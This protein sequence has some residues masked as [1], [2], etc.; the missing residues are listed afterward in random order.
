M[1][2]ATQ[3]LAEDSM[4]ESVW[5]ST[6]ATSG[7]PGPAC[8]AQYAFKYRQSTNAPGYPC[9]VRTSGV[10]PL[11]LGSMNQAAVGDSI[12][13]CTNDPLISHVFVVRAVGADGLAV[14]DYKGSKP[15][16]CR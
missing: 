12:L 3:C 1:F 11:V 15:L 10:Y 4:T 9:D 13:Q 7:C 6:G 2:F 8:H 14:A 16:P 5:V